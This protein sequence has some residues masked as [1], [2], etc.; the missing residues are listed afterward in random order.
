MKTQKLVGMLVDNVGHPKCMIELPGTPEKAGQGVD[1]EHD[2]DI[3]FLVIGPGR[4]PVYTFWVLDWQKRLAKI[5]YVVFTEVVDSPAWV[6]LTKTYHGTRFGSLYLMT[7]RSGIRPGI[8]P[9]QRGL[10]MK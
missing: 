6:D 9:S 1:L 2:E 10:Y 7:Y 4:D 5:C 3:D 8:L